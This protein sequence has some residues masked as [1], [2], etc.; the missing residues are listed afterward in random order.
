MNLVHVLNAAVVAGG[1]TTAEVTLAMVAS[2]V[3][4]QLHHH[5]QS[6]L[7]HH[8]PSQLQLLRHHLLAP[9]IPEIQQRNMTAIMKVARLALPPTAKSAAMDAIS[10][11]TQAKEPTAWKIRQ[12]SQFEH[13]R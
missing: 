8:R 13:D 9:V 12:C 6:Q 2:Q 10:R 11:Q 3:P 1:C 4:S 5:R 7:H